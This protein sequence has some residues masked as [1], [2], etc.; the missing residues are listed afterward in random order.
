MLSVATA[1][2]VTRV[3]S[4]QDM[5]SVVSF[6]LFS[7]RKV[8]L[9]SAS[10]MGAIGLVPGMPNFAFLSFSA[11][12]FFIAF[13]D[14]FIKPTVVEVVDEVEEA[15]LANKELNWNEIKSLDIIALDIG[16]R[17]IPLL[18]VDQGGKLVEQIRSTRRKLSQELGFL[19]HTVHV[20]DNL[21][22]PPNGYKIYLLGVPEGEGIIYADKLLA[23]DSGSVTTKIQGIETK[24]P[25]FNMDAVWIEHG[26]KDHA[27]SIGYTVVDPNTVILTHLSQI[28]N[29]SAHHLFGYQEAQQLLDGLST[30]AP[31]LVEDLIPKLIPLA[32]F[33]KVLQNL[34]EEKISIRNIRT[35]AETLADQAQHTQDADTLTAAVRI[36]LKRHIT[37]DAMGLHDELVAMTIDNDLEQLLLQ[38]LSSNQESGGI[39]IEPDF[40]ERLFSS[41]T[42]VFKQQESFGHSP[43]LLVSPALRKWLA[44]LI[45][46]SIPGLRVLAY[47]EISENKKIKIIASIGNELKR[48][49]VGNQAAA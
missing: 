42:D 29:S 32:T 2:I 34:L 20:R 43:V 22:I 8:M 5:N 45:A 11:L 18:D 1:I 15:P 30:E 14:K 41:I 47:N 27:K 23:I 39:G 17:L 13:R 44:K 36:S 40:A 33:V 25:A 35:I 4:S 7:Q 19:I 31:K 46:H 21:D 24:D 26:Q 12:L 49:G 38:S 6:Q 10:I 48:K 37:Q 16:F 9:V 3:S 28:I